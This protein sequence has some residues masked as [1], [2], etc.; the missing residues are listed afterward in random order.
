MSLHQS[1]AGY[2][3][4]LRAMSSAAGEPMVNSYPYL[5]R[6]LAGEDAHSAAFAWAVG[7]LRAVADGCRQIRAVAHPLGFVCL[8]L[9][10]VGGDGV[11]LHFWSPEVP[12]GAELTTSEVHS[13]SWQLTSLVLFGQLQ[14]DEVTVV[15]VPGA[16]LAQDATLPIYRVLEIHSHGSVDVLLP[17][18]RLVT[19]WR[20]RATLTSVGDVYRLPAGAFHA[21]RVDP[22]AEAVTIALGKTIHGAANHALGH[23][24][25]TVHQVPRRFFGVSETA[26]LT[27][28]IIDRLLSVWDSSLAR[29][30]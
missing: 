15:D 14:N 1:Y 18:G 2:T 21:T 8:P 10:R 24:D 4:A 3:T 17:T 19:S 23:V 20:E 30:S 12:A 9:Q 13:H 25:S 28:T 27:C 29:R 5:S 6:T 26:K 11:C 7:E 16:E 22:S